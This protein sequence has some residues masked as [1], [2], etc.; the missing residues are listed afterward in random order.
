[1]LGIDRGTPAH[2]LKPEAKRIPS[3]LR[4]DRPAALPLAPPPR[5][6]EHSP[7]GST[8]GRLAIEAGPADRRALAPL[9]PDF[10]LGPS[11]EPPMA[12]AAWSRAHTM[13][14]LARRAA[15]LG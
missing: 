6:F 12:I 14:R 2:S 8:L 9:F 4:L 3:D 5:G 1:M 13:P 15:A 11:R 10:A 7:P